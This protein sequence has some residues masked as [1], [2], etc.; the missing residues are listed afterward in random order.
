M[1]LRPPLSARCSQH[2]NVDQPP[3]DCRDCELGRSVWLEREKDSVRR[4]TRRLV[5]LGVIPRRPCAHCCSTNQLQIHHLDYTDPEHIV[6]LCGACHRKEH[7]RR[8]TV[9]R[10]ITFKYLQHLLVGTK[11]VAPE[12]PQQRQVGP[13]RREDQSGKVAT[14]DGLLRFGRATA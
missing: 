12:R 9:G 1:R 14:Y 10:S 7:L 3:K 8:K 5:K 11:V 13:R 2:Q 4:S 6:W